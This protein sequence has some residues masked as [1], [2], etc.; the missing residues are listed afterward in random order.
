MCVQEYMKIN[1]WTKEYTKEYMRVWYQKNKKTQN[2][3]SKLWVK[4]NRAKV[5][6]YY[7]KFK[8]GIGEEEQL[9]LL[10]GSCEICPKKATHID[11]DHKTRKVRGGL[12]NNCNTGLGMFCDNPDLL[13]KAAE[14]VKSKLNEK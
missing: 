8:Y 10:G 5:N 6:T 13:I 9:R 1:K 4:N 7:R 2:E 12:C 14:Y 11:H 3:K